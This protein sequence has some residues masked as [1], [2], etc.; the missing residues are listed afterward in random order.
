MEERSCLTLSCH[1]LWLGQVRVGA[2]VETEGRNWVRKCEGT[3]LAGL[4][5]MACSV[6]SL[7]QSKTTCW[8]V[9]PSTSIIHQGNAPHRL[10]STPIS[11]KH[12]LTWG[13]LFPDSSLCQVYKKLTR[14]RINLLRHVHIFVVKAFSFWKWAVTSLSVLPTTIVS[15]NNI[16][17]IMFKLCSINMLLWKPQQIGS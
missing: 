6:Y 13:S 9:G 15:Y 7:I 12:F 2:Q 11:W 16:K 1:Y 4:H 10:A 8:G 14:T 17:F 5:S 3:P